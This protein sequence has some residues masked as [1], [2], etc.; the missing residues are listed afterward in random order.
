MKEEIKKLISLLFDEVDKL[1]KAIGKENYH[2]EV[3]T[4]MLEYMMYLS[5]ADDEIEWTEILKIG[6]YLGFTDLNPQNIED[7][8][9]E[10][11]IGSE[12]FENTIPTIFKILVDH[13]NMVYAKNPSNKKFL[14]EIMTIVYK[15]LGKE[16]VESDGEVDKYEYSNFYTYDKLLNDYLDQKLLARASNKNS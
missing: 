5:M 14:S 1:G 11:R 7:Y 8:I 4:E 3:A 12:K 15:A 13:D 9:I 10:H 2:I 16:L 6:L